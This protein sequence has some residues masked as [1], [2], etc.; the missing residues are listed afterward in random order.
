MASNAA[1]R[2]PARSWSGCSEGGVYTTLKNLG[3][4]PGIGLSVSST[5]RP[6]LSENAPKHAIATPLSFQST[7]SICIWKASVA[8]TEVLSSFSSM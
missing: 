7:P 1:M 6:Q 4:P 5:E 3:V 2:L 8:G